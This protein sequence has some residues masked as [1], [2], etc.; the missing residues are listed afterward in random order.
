MMIN[1]KISHDL[2]EQI[3]IYYYGI[4]HIL[5]Q[6]YSTIKKEVLSIVL[7]LKKFKMSYLIKCF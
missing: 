7:C 2:K 1:K 5:Q 6:K 3:V 4:W